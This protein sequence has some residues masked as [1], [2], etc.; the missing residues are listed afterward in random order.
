MFEYLCM[1]ALA[2]KILDGLSLS[3]AVSRDE[4]PVQT[5]FEIINCLLVPL[6]KFGSNYSGFLDTLDTFFIS[7]EL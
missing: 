4:L 3:L 2:K 7:F 1:Y 5:H 6:P